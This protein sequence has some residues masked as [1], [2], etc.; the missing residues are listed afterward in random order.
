MAHC[1]RNRLGFDIKENKEFSMLF[2]ILSVSTKTISVYLN[3]SLFVLLNI[4]FLISLYTVIL[5]NV[6]VKKMRN[7]SNCVKSMKLGI[8]VSLKILIG[9]FE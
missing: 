1:H 9:N 4:K 7:T 8:V 2:C 3:K 5:K 6:I